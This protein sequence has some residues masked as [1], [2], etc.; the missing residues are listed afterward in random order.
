[1]KSY[2]KYYK[3]IIEVNSTKSRTIN[4]HFRKR[5]YRHRQDYGAI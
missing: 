4:I 5:D 3:T 2:Y 1:M